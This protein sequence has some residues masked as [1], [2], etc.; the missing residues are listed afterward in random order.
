MAGKNV[1]NARL[2]ITLVSLL[3]SVDKRYVKT[4]HD[5]LFRF[6]KQRVSNMVSKLAARRCNHRTPQYNFYPRSHCRP[7]LSLRLSSDNCP[8]FQSR[9]VEWRM[10][11]PRFP[12][13]S[14]GGAASIP[15]RT[16]RQ[17]NRLEDVPDIASLSDTGAN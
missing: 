16:A 2:H 5:Q 9:I 8:P 6:Q 13:W 10:S 11:N 7:R 15:N 14:Y 4:C 17:I 12:N 1:L 3:P